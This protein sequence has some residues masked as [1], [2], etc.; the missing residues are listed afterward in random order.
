[1]NAKPNIASEEMTCDLK[2]KL[3]SN[4]DTRLMS[5]VDTRSSL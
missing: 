2:L 1:M 5:N 3:M 4:V